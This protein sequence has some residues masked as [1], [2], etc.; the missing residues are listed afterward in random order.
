MTSHATGQTSTLS[1]LIKGG[2]RV[3]GFDTLHWMRRVM[4]DDC[5]R[6]ITELDPSQLDVLEISAGPHWRTMPFRSYAELNYPD[7]DICAPLT[8]PK[9]YDLII[10]DQVFEHLLW[11]YRAAKNVFSL[12]RPGGHFLITTPFLIR[13]HMVPTDCSRWTESGIRYF[14]AECGFPLDTIVSRSWGNRACVK[15][16]FRRWARRGW[17]RSLKNEPDFPVAVWAFAQKPTNVS[18]ATSTEQ[19]FV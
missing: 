5:R 14:L 3:V 11:P 10:A 1:S 12:L 6:F 15:A 4:Y 8:H 13:V 16:N 18:S 17:L 19:V 9:Q 7:F 2:L